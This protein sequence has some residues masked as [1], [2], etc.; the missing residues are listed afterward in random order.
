MD[1]DGRSR[2]LLSLLVSILKDLDDVRRVVYLNVLISLS[3]RRG[4]NWDLWPSTKSWLNPLLP[5][6]LSFCDAAD[7]SD[8]IGSVFVKPVGKDYFLPA[9]DDN[10]LPV[11][12]HEVD[13]MGVWI[14]I[15]YL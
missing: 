13:A 10:I 15:L 2:T 8:V 1:G 14:D 9:P 4:G 11:G 3:S 7:G 5:L 12:T 6:L